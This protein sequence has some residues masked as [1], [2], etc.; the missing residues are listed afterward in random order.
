MT[1]RP[2]PRSVCWSCPLRTSHSRV[3]PSLLLVATWFWSGRQTTGQTEPRCR[4]NSCRTWPSAVSQSWIA[5]S[6]AAVASRLPSPLNRT[7]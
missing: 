7:L 2:C 6:L 3:V 1:R 4:V 5:P